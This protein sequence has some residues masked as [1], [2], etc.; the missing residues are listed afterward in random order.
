MPTLTASAYGYCRG[1]SKKDSSDKPRY[2]ILGLA[3]RGLLP[4]LTISG[5]HNRKGASKNSG[6]G[7]FSA[8]GAQPS[9]E[10]L[11]AFMGFP[12][13]WVAIAKTRASVIRLLGNAVYPACA[14]VVGR[15]I[16]ELDRHTE[17]R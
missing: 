7:L 1:G 5:N 6:D 10:W 11:E 13:G 17:A 2:S 14:E 15:F 3:A 4:T 9:R 16:V 12:Q 8:V